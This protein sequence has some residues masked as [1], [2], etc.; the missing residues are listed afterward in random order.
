MKVFIVGIVA[1]GKTTLAR[2]LSKKYGVPYFEGD[3][4]AWGFP[5]EARYKRSPEEQEATIQKI[6]IAPHWIIEGTYRSSQR[7]LFDLA[8]YIVFLDTPLHVRRRRIITR[9]LKQKLGVEPSHY[10]PSLEMLRMMFKWT[11]DFEANRAAYEM[12]LEAYG[13]KVIRMSRITKEDVFEEEIG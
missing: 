1:S 6:N 8:D 4:I 2:E 11:Q 5:G 9:Y 10:K 7:R 12:M 3:C 13:D